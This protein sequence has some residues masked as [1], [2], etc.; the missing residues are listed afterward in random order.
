MTPSGAMREDATASLRT[1]PGGEAAFSPPG[2]SL[3][4][5]RERKTPSSRGRHASPGAQAGGRFSRAAAMPSCGS[6]VLKDASKASM[7]GGI[8]LSR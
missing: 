4:L 1:P 7:E 3:R 5:R 2:L 6:P 8:A